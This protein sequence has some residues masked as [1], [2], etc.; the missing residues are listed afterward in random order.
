MVN[1]CFVN[2]IL[3]GKTDLVK[4]LS[5]E[6]G[7]NNQQHNEFFNIIGISR[8]QVW[9][10]RAATNNNNDGIP[11]ICIV[12]EKQMILSR[13]LKILPSPIILVR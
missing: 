11:D 7:A 2:P 5:N 6:N 8:E 4:K 10:Q 3:P 9:I 13:H 1:Y 12:V